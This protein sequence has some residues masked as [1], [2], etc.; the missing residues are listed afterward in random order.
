M[1][2]G[3]YAAALV[4]WREAVAEIYRKVRETH[5]RDAPEAWRRFR[6]ERDALY[7]HHPCSALSDARR[8]RFSGFENF[9]YDPGLCLLGEVEYEGDPKTYA[10]RISEGILPYRRIGKARF[11]FR[12]APYSLGLF[13]LDIYGGG[14]WL[15]VADATNGETSYAG[16]RYLFDT[17]KGANLGFG[18]DGKTILLDFNFLYPP[19][20]ALNSQWAC[21]LCPPEN[22]LPFPVEAGEMS[23]AARAPRAALRAV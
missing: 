20:C 13:W 19:S 23:E 7:A 10:T 18:P 1:V 17:A 22:R 3:P 5:G 8:L 16:G 15:P 9:P 21:P 6:L 2:S 4:G 12:G 14:I 11:A